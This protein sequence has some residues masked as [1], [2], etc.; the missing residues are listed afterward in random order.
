MK[1]TKLFTVISMGFIVFFLSSCVTTSQ[2]QLNSDFDE[3]MYE[4]VNSKTIDI[5]RSVTYDISLSRPG[6]H[7]PQVA[8]F[9]SLFSKIEDATNSTNP[10]F[11]TYRR[12]EILGS[13]IEIEALLYDKVSYASL[14]FNDG[15]SEKR[16]TILTQEQIDTLVESKYFNVTHKDTDNLTVEKNGNMTVYSYYVKQEDFA[17]HYDNYDMLLI[18]F[19]IKELNYPE[20]LVIDYINYTVFV[21]ENKRIEKTFVESSINVNTEFETIPVMVLSE[22]KYNSYGKPVTFNYPDFNEYE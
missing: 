4:L 17:N 11:Y 1:K 18:A 15:N 19:G 12:E 9:V 22:T 21:N 8:R 20:N 10:T 16:K 3:V 2:A 14:N 5:E 13:F 6:L 7:E